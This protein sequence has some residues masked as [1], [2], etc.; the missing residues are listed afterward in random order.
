MAMGVFMPG[1]AP[2][3]SGGGGGGGLDGMITVGN[4]ADFVFGWSDGTGGLGIPAIG[5][6]TGDAAPFFVE[7]FAWIP[8]IASGGAYLSGAY[9]GAVLSFQ[10][11]DYLS[12]YDNVADLW[13]FFFGP[14]VATWPTS[15]T[16]PFTLTLP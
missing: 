13:A 11:E 3:M 8:S 14:E 9:A 15:G 12:A 5:S 1:P 2:L 10:G 4:Y 16:Y 6:L 7:L